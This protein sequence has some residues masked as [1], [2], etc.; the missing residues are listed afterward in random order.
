MKY[1]RKDMIV[2]AVQW[3]KKGDSVH[4]HT[5]SGYGYA[6][7]VHGKYPGFCLIKPGDWVLEHEDGNLSTMRAAEFAEEFI[8]VME[9][10]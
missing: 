2:Q 8:V 5:I 9:D 4:V 3:F 7:R 6:I 1:R 10:S